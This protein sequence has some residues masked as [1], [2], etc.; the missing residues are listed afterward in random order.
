MLKAM[1]VLSCNAGDV[2]FTNTHIQRLENGQVGDLQYF[3][4]AFPAG[5]GPS[6]RT[7][8]M[9]AYMDAQPSRR[10]TPPSFCVFSTAWVFHVLGRC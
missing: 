6:D 4:E 1:C 9:F 3:W 2:I 5:S 8:Y 7:T 10:V